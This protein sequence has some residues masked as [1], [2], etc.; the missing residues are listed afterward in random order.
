M[1]KHQNILTW[2]VPL[3]LFLALG[4]QSLLFALDPHK[5]IYQYGHSV[6][7]RQNGLP[8][9][10]V[11][12]GFQG[13]DGYL[14][15]GTSA[16]LFRFDGVN[17]KAVITN[18][19]NGNN[20]ETIAALCVTKD[21]SLWVG[22]AYGGL[23]RIKNEKVTVFDPTNDTTIKL[24]SSQIKVLLES[25]IGN[26][27]IGT[28]NGLYKYS[29]GRFSGVPFSENYIT[30]LAEDSLDRIWVGTYNGIRIFND[31]LAKQVD[32]IT[33]TNGLPHNMVS[34]LLS[35]CRGNI[36]IGTLDGLV[37]WN[38]NK[39][40]IYKSSDGLSE[41]HITTICEDRDHNLWFGTYKGIS[42]FSY[43]KWSSF[44]AEDGLTND[45]VLSMIEDYEGSLWVC[46]IEGL[47]RFKDVN[48]ATYTTKEGLAYDN[49]SGV[50]ETSDGSLFFLSDVNSSITQ[51]KNNHVSKIYHFNVG[52]AYVSRDGSLWI[53]QTGLL[54]KIKN[55]QLVRYN[56]ANGLP[57]RWISAVTEDHNSLIIN[58]DR[59]GIR[60]FV[61]GHVEPYVMKNGKQY[62][63]TEFVACFYY[64]S[65]GILWVGTTGGL[66]KI[67]RGVSTTFRQS[68]GLAGNWINSIFDDKK[69]SLW[70]S[71][72]RDGITHYKDGI[73]T[74][75]TFKDGLFT[76][77]VYCILCD[78][79]GSVWL[80]SPRGIG[81]IKH[82]ELDDFIG[83]RIKSIHTQVY[84]TAD[85]MKSDDCFG[86]YQPAGWKAHDGRLWFATKKGAVMIDPKSFKRNLFPPPVIIEE[87]L[88]DQKIV[89]LDHFVTLSPG[90]E[91]F[92]FH[93]T[94]L[95]F[96]TPERVLFKYLLEG[97]DR[98]WVDAGTRRVAYYTNLPPGQYR[99]C[100]MACNNDGVWNET[101][102]SFAFELVPHFYQTYWF[103]ALLIVCVVGVAFGGYR[104]RVWQLL[105]REEELKESVDEA[106]KKI[107]VLGGLI[108]ICANCKKIRDDKGYWDQLER[109][110]QT[111]SEA[112]FTHGICPD[113][114]QKLFA[115][116]SPA[117]KVT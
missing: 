27:W 112:Q 92:E 64:Q 96:L 47:N 62:P 97:Y 71:S 33:T 25:R 93:Y 101:G 107:K 103:Y 56:T 6:W 36:W 102:T 91:K 108:P 78:D 54:S 63:S 3:V 45:H 20:V 37:R 86:G 89:P 70:I 109:Y 8:A 68:E 104:L 43:G 111:H 7:Y 74:P 21:S 34:S 40:T 51:V 99:F 82:Q 39:L 28:S 114:A 98:E 87:M 60:R 59:V 10:A 31:D 22:T 115:N 23:R 52:P 16:G 95:S 88:A 75:I 30:A 49:I 55:N 44:T 18:P 41:N 24:Y 12:V 65:N 19:A 79:S 58:V 50:A 94:A 1:F 105:K 69:G 17:F 26:L 72:P 38:R 61:N 4:E 29:H 42:R 113:C 35:D 73:F 2:F 76:N 106:L 100:V 11:N 90:K 83:G 66:V 53:G 14:W 116:I 84:V 9:N 80:S 48:I 85:G 67:Q 15:L 117:K 57:V 110:I 77:E 32:S 5:T 46:T 81:Y 13:Q